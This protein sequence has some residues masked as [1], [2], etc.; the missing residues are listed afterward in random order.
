MDPILKS[1]F[2]VYLLHVSPAGLRNITFHQQRK[3]ASVIF[4]FP[5]KIAHHQNFSPGESPECHRRGDPNGDSSR[6]WFSIHIGEKRNDRSWTR[7]DVV[8]LRN[9]AIWKN[10]EIRRDPKSMASY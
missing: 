3:D 2:L 4:C 5:M 9:E 1:G 6:A 8:D 10:G 7:T